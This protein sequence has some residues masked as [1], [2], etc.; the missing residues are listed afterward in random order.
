MAA[1][2]LSREWHHAA[3]CSSGSRRSVV[4]AGALVSS[5]RLPLFAQ[6]SVVV[7]RSVVPVEG[8]AL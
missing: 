4:V 8:T 2:R 5:M 7:G 6:V 3:S 1:V